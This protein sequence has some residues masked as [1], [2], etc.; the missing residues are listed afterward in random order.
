MEY[1]KQ[2]S[3][4]LDATGKGKTFAQHEEAVSAY[5]NKFKEAVT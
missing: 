1:Y 4:P 3:D 5:V 2:T